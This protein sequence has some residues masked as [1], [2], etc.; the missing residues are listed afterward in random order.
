MAAEQMSKPQSGQDRTS[1][2]IVMRRRLLTLTD[3]NRF[4]FVRATVL[5]L[6]A[7]GWLGVLLVQTTSAAEQIS[8]HVSPFGN[9]ANPGSPD[10]PFATLARAQQATRQANGGVVIVRAGTYYLPETLVFTPADNG[11]EYR[12]AKGETVV[13]SG[14]RKLDL[15]WMPYRD[16]ILQAKT[17]AGLAMDQ[18]FVNGQ[19]QPMARYPNYDPNA[20][21]F[22]GSAADAIAP[23]RVARWSNPAGGYIHA[24][25]AALWGD[26]H[27]RILGKKS[28]GS[29][30][31]EGGWQNNRP[32]PMHKRFRF[33][34]NIREELDAPGEWFHDAPNATL[35]FFPPTGVDLPAATVEV[36]R[37]RRLV[38]FQGT[39][40]HPVKG[41][42]LRGLTFR[43]AA[44]TFMDNREPLLR[45]DWTVYRGGAVVLNGAENVAIEDCDFDQ[46]GGNAIFV[47]NYNRRGTVRECL[48]RESGA[49]GIAFVGDPKAVRSALFNYGAPFDYAKLDRTPG[50]NGDN[51]P[52]DCLVEDCLITRSGRFEKQTAPV[53]IS[54]SQNITVRHCSIYDVPRAGINIGD[55][56]WGGHII[57]DC[58]IFDT[59]LETGDHGSF[60]SWGRDR[61]WHPDVRRVDRQAAADPALPFL[62]MVKPTIL[63]HNRWRCDHGWDIDLDDGSSRYIICD[64]LLLHGGLKMREGYG[65]VATNNVII[66]NSLHPHVWFENSGDVFARNIVMGPYRPARMDIAKWG[67][68]VDHNLFATSEADRQKFAGKGCDANSL[69]GDPLFV[70]A[71]N[72]D[73]RVKD[74]SPA[75]KLGFVN[76]PMDQFGVRSP[77]L[78]L[79]ARTPEIPNVKIVAG[80]ATTSATVETK[81]QGAT[82][83]AL[84][85]YEFSALG[86][87]ADAG[88]IFVAEVPANS[89]AF[90]AGLR[91]GD[92][93]QRVNGRAVRD[94]PEF[95]Q[96]MRGVAA[97]QALKLALIRNQQALSLEAL[98]K[99]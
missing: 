93:I 24:M 36:V 72:G 52:A 96:A 85:P 55:G 51:F 56:C 80:E 33:V 17:P 53:Q 82:L 54:M 31:Y 84:L 94:V 70:D 81:W 5:A 99:P 4:S 83:R 69:V 30:D 50:P 89:A 67:K 1:S 77:R 20:R 74:N 76:F 2:F 34:E 27:W 66:N 97:G 63:R 95:L 6:G 35:Y 49:N 75:R 57:E 78:R 47:N 12:A 39:K 98:L 23:E 44:R 9:D 58:D 38:E 71:A 21:Q 16:G 88:G 7:L 87:A 10:R 26:M 29:L 19:R 91:Q 43:H 68:E 45:S 8:L 59:V 48:I 60:N 42:T 40:E 37:L 62:D 61:Y 14:G 65:R 86:V 32:S 46:L 73:C 18:L 25:H 11:T 64:N 79:I 90:A 28:D 41:I 15:K 22:N 92:F 3:M 13:I